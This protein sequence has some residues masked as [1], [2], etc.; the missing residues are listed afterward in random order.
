VSKTTNGGSFLA[1]TLD[2][3]E[4]IH[5]PLPTF[6]ETPSTTRSFACFWYC[7]NKVMAPHNQPKWLL[8]EIAN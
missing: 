2:M 1:P 3:F 4:S 5:L 6:A 7:V 8:N